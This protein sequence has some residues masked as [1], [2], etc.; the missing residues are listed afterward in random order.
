MTSLPCS[1]DQTHVIQIH[2]RRGLE[3]NHDCM[4]DTIR[5]AKV[6][7]A[8]PFLVNIPLYREHNIRVNENWISGFNN[9]EKVPFIASDDDTRLV[10]EQISLSDNRIPIVP[11][12]AE[13]Y[14]GGQ[15]SLLDNIPIE[16]IDYNR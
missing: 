13:L 5:P 12:S 14:P 9:Q 8:L 2:L 15:K 3:Y 6:I 11:L 4:T 1:F 10:E 16:H 7:E